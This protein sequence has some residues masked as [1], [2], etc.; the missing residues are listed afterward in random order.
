[1]LGPGLLRTCH[2]GILVPFLQ[3]FR[4]LDALPLLPDLFELS[5][6]LRIFPVAYHNLR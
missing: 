3:A 5:P 4:H 1:M 2:N 6:L